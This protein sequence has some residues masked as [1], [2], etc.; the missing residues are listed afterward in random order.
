MTDLFQLNLGILALLFKPRAKLE[1][2]T[3]VVTVRSLIKKF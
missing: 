2:E 1:A 3:L